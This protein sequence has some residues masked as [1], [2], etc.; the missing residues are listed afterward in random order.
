MGTF[1]ELV[2]YVPIHATDELFDSL[3]SVCIARWRL[4]VLPEEEEGRAK[5][6]A[7]RP[8]LCGRCRRHGVP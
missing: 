7:A 1:L 4:S 5:D 8:L 2:K 3:S 6:E